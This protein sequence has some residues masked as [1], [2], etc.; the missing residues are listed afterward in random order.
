MLWH[1]LHTKHSCPSDG[2]AALVLCWFCLAQGLLC[3]RDGSTKARHV[4]ALCDKGPPPAACGEYPGQDHQAESVGPRE[5]M[6]T[7]PRS[8]PEHVST[9]KSLRI[10]KLN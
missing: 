4:M 9:Q 5:V 6:S 10:Q 2:M 3:W 1:S 7:P 8:L